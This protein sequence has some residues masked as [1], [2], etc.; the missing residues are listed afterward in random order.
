[1]YLVDTSVWI[2][3]FRAPPRVDLTAYGDFDDL[4]VC[5][6]IV[7]EILQGIDRDAAFARVRGALLAM[8]IVEAPLEPSLF[9]EAVDLYR[10]ARRAGVTLR[11]SVDCLIAACALRHHLT[12]L[13]HD[14]DFTALAR[15][16]MLEAQNVPLV[17]RPGRA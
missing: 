7:Q 14:R 13:H 3:H 17:G 4:A 8:P 15:V 5:L 11:S 12:V 9:D 1:V 10:R 16:S 6:P 2:E